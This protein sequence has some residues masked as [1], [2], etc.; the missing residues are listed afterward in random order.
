MW[1]IIDNIHVGSYGNPACV[2][3]YLSAACTHQLEHI[4]YV[5]QPVITQS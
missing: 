2:T 4:N 5:H 3:C 1:A